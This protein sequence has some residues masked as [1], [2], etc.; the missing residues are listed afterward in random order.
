MILKDAAAA[1]DA[2]VAEQ[3]QKISGLYED[4]AHEI[5]QQAKFYAGKDGSYALKSAQYSQ[6]E[7]SITEQ[8]H[9][10]SN[11]V[12][13][14]AK[15]SIYYVSDAVVQSCANWAA[16]M[17]FGGAGLSAAFNSVPQMTVNQLVTGQIYEGGW[18]LSAAIWGN[19]EKELESI[20]Q[21][22][23]GGLAKNQ[24]VFETAKQLEQYVS[25]SAAKQ[26]NLT[27]ADGRRIYPRSVDYSSQR[28]VRTLTQH[29]YQSSLV[30]MTKNNPFISLSSIYCMWTFG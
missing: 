30:T 1:R 26:W 27:S 14:T 21:I 10:V 17:G 8:S 23:A 11:Q 15:D 12:Y 18:N 3:Y 22:V 29:G 6:F 25:P 9:V 2:I 5:G 16:T 24:P 13:Q 19:N 28:L 7:K 4:W 20:Y